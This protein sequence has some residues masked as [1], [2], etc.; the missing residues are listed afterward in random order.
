MNGRRHRVRRFDSQFVKS[1]CRTSVHGMVLHRRWLERRPN[2]LSVLI[3]VDGKHITRST[4]TVSPSLQHILSPVLGSIVRLSCHFATL[5]HR[6]TILDSGDPVEIDTSEI[7]VRQKQKASAKHNS[8]HEHCQYRYQQVPDR[9]VFR[10]SF[11]GV[12]S[13]GQACQPKKWKS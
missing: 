2:D 8:A 4:N 10:L 5:A 12:F 1:A 11:A 13:N 6:H 7:V 9:H 3:E